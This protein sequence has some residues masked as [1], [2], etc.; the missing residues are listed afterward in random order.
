MIGLLRIPANPAESYHSISH[1][2]SLRC[3]FDVLLI[4]LIMPGTSTRYVNDCTTTP[5]TS[6]P[7]VV[8]Q[9]V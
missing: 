8:I 4:K 2:A 9:T 5:D 6:A 7:P 1:E 3:R